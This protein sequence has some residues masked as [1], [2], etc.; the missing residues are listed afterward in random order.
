MS[1]IVRGYSL[2]FDDHACIGPYKYERFDRNSIINK[3]VALRIAYSR[4]VGSTFAWADLCQDKF[5]YRMEAHIPD[6]QNARGIA[7]MIRSGCDGLS[8]RFRTLSQRSNE[9]VTVIERARLSEI[10]IVPEGAYASA[11]CWV[12]GDLRNAPPLIQ[13]LASD[14]AKGRIAGMSV[15]GRGVVAIQRRPDSPIPTYA[16][17]N[18]FPYVI[19]TKA[20]LTRSGEV[21]P[22]RAVVRK[23][24]HA[25]L[26][27]CPK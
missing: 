2:R 10:S 24:M 3:R 11:R 1:E 6:R 15:M 17:P 23:H 18:P 14:W 19:Q 5:G 13:S 26:A 22:V 8:V 21:D 4:A 9:T 12:V 27:R 20:K 25:Y 7:R 16:E